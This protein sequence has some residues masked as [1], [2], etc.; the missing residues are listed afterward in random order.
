MLTPIMSIPVTSVMSTLVRSV[1]IYLVR[2]FVEIRIKSLNHLSLSIPAFSTPDISFKV[3][4]SLHFGI[5]NVN[6]IFPRLD[7]T[8]DPL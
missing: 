5:Q 3:Y 4:M 7:E 8:S 1:T 6:N 2:L